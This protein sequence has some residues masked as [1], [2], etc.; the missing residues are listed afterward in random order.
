MIGRS[1]WDHKASMISPVENVWAIWVFIREPKM[2]STFSISCYV[3]DI[4]TRCFELYDT[5]STPVFEGRY[6]RQEL[7]FFLLNSSNRENPI[8][9]RKPRFHSG[10]RPDWSPTFFQNPKISPARTQPEKFEPDWQL[11]CVHLY[12]TLCC[13]NV[14]SHT[15]S[16]NHH[17]EI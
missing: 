10:V 16:I 11:W 17:F 13:A 1:L 12:S 14:S 8:T 4:T 2:Q 7:V 9:Y 5:K 3:Y 6:M 15:S